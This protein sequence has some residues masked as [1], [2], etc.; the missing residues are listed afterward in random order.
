LEL[1]F[2]QEYPFKPFKLQFVDRDLFHPQV[3]EDGYIALDL[4]E[5]DWSP[6]IAG[7]ESEVLLHVQTMLADPDRRNN[8]TNVDAGVMCE[9]SLQAWAEEVQYRRDP[10]TALPWWERLIAALPAR[11]NPDLPEI[12]VMIRPQSGGEPFEMSASPSEPVVT[13]LWRAARR[14]GVGFYGT[15]LSMGG[16]I[17]PLHDGEWYDLSDLGIQAGAQL[18]LVEDNVGVGAEAIYNLTQL[19]AVVMAMELSQA[20]E[21]TQTAAVAQQHAPTRVSTRTKRVSLRDEQ[22]K[23]EATMEEDLQRVQSMM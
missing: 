15:V 6:G 16:E 9:E 23:M 1:Q 4:L 5:H 11:G 13:L 7:H 14:S 17:L 3:W 21:D 12:E 2:P 20:A 8:C 18:V 10:S 19:K 22:Q